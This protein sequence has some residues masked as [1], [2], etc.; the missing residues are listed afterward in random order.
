MKCYNKLYFHLHATM[1]TSMIAFHDCHPDVCVKGAVS[2]I[3]TL[4]T[5]QQPSSKFAEGSSGQ[6]TS[7]NP[8][9]SSDAPGQHPKELWAPLLRSSEATR[10]PWPWNIP[11]IGTQ[12]PRG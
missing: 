11:G 10:S 6:N 9:A 7:Q 4:E 1:G 5:S 2:S 8:W 3:I 12:G